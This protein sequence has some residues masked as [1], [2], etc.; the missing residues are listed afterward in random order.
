[1]ALLALLVVVVVA[2]LCVG[3][4]AVGWTMETPQPSSSAAQQAR[5][6]YWDALSQRANTQAQLDLVEYL[7]TQCQDR[8][9]ADAQ[10]TVAAQQQCQA[11][12][13]RALRIQNTP[14]YVLDE[15][16]QA[17]GMDDARPAVVRTTT[18][19]PGT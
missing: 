19:G 15:Q 16:L 8:G 17:L 4:V 7:K 11:E 2:G 18:V 9:G 5:N 12:Q 14:I 6:A 13:V 3:A 10:T 1:M